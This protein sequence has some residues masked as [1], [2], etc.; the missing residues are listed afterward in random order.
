MKEKKSKLKKP[1]NW[2]RNRH[3]LKA[4]PNPSKDAYEIK[5]KVPELT[6]EGVRAQPD[7]AHLYIT[8]YPGS[9]IIELKSLKEYFFAFRSQIFSYERIINVIYD[10]MMNVYEP[11]RLRLVM[12]C[13]PRGGISSK[14][15]ADSDWGIRGGKDRFKDWLGQRDEW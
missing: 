12:T 4:I 7:F 13:N 14:L 1:R 8:F 9:K 6:F 15:T 2:S 3:I 5:M 11:V 10:D